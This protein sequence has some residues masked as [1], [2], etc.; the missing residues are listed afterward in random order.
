MEE[1][2]ELTQKEIEHIF[3]EWDTRFRENP[4]WFTSQAESLLKGTPKTYGENCA[5][6]FVALYKEVIKNEDN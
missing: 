6:Y 3:T 4:E 5:P 1:T 2:I